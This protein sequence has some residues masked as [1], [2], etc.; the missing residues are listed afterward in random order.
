MNLWRVAFSWCRLIYF[1]GYGCKTI[2]EVRN[3]SSTSFIVEEMSW[4]NDTKNTSPQQLHLSVLCGYCVQTLEYSF[5]FCTHD[6]IPIL[7]FRQQ[8]ETRYLGAGA[9][10]MKSV[11]LTHTLK[12]GAS[13]RLG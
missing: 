13:Q 5:L 7:P 6:H 3:T 10:T 8:L 12:R 9:G 1:G 2:G 4:V 11:F